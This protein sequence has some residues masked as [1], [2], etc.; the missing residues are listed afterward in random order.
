MVLVTPTGDEVFVAVQTVAWVRRGGS[1]VS[2]DE[3]RVGD[4][5]TLQA[6]QLGWE[7]AP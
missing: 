3:L 6:A 7:T 5:V 2:P 4:Y 1:F